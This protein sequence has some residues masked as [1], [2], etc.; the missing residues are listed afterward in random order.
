M[1]TPTI[2]QS[3]LKLPVDDLETALELLRRP[4]TAEAVKF[5][6]QSKYGPG[7]LAVGYIDV[8]LVIERL[9]AVV[10]A[11]WH[12]EYDAIRG[13]DGKAD[14]MWC[15][16]TVFGTTR[17]DV[18]S[19]YRG[20]GLVSDALKR[21][22]VKFGVGVSI[23]ASPSVVLSPDDGQARIVQREGKGGPSLYITDKGE[24]RCRDT[25]AE[26]LEE[27]GKRDFGE[28]I[29]HGDVEASAGAEEAEA[30]E[31]GDVA[32]AV[33]LPLVDALA[34]QLRA[35]ARSNY[36]ELKKVDKAARTKL[37]PARF[38][39]RLAQASTSHE[40]LEAL[41]KELRETVEEAKKK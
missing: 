13:N 17:R 33:Q 34:D 25:Y 1:T 22:A 27:R 23:Y 11:F 15:H 6:A 14:A 2:E 19:G 16:L 7:V 9:N 29:D 30:A 31:P 8:R 24:A 36:E 32:E 10:G 4:F 12:D 5:K 37:P 35:T 20:K 41:C 26:W 40:D 3:D 18:G 28:P 38:Q 21:A 39:E